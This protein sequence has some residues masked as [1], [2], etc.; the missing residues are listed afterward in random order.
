MW[1]VSSLIIKLDNWLVDAYF[2]NSEAII[3]AII[4][5]LSPLLSLLFNILIS[6]D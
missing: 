3:L 2:I 5:I 1:F 4:N 6:F